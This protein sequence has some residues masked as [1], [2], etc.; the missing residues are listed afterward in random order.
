MIVCAWCRKSLIERF[1]DET[2][3]HSLCKGCLLV[4]TVCDYCLAKLVRTLDGEAVTG[5]LS[6]ASTARHSR[7]CSTVTGTNNLRSGNGVY[8]RRHE[9]EQPSSL[10]RD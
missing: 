6:A 9:L 2:A 1:R 8:A 10:P 4:H 3:M 5:P 7:T